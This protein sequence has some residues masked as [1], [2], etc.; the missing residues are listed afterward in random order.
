VDGI[1]TRVLVKV[2]QRV[3]KGDSLAEI[4]SAEVGIARDDVRKRRDD[5]DIARQAAE[6]SAG[7]ADNVQSLLTLLDNHTPLAEVEA[8]F[9]GRLLGAYRERILAAYSKLLYVEKVNAD[10]VQLGAGGVL[11]TR[12]IQERTSNLEVARASFS[13]TCEEARFATIQ[14]RAKAQAALDQAKRLLQVAEE[15][16]RTLVGSRL[17]ASATT[18]DE[19][20][21]T[22]TADEDGISAITLRTPLA[23]I[24]EEVFVSRGE[25]VTG[26]EQMFV[27]ADTSDLWV[28]AQVH[29]KQWTSVEV[30]DGQEVSLV[31]PGAEEHRAKATINHIG[32]TVDPDSRSVPIVADLANDDAHFKPGMFVW[33]ELPQGAPRDVLAVPETAVMRHEDRAF[34]FVPSDPG[35][36]RR[37]DVTTGITD[38]GWIEVSKGLDPGQ[39]VVAGGA[40]LLKSEMLLEDEG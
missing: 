9:D 25:R 2:R 12:I 8:A 22:S 19:A 14:D 24:V 35:R 1:V 27:V 28:R 34:V 5:L 7:I 30:A 3:E 15:N 38:E 10:T 31:M 17:D 33:V 32:A 20:G 29:E 23:G 40:F 6:W 21:D 13:A 18:L 37:V 36:Y 39:Q 26:G 11:S 16:L 4:S